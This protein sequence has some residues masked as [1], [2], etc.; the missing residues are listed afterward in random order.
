VAKRIL[1]VALLA[2]T[3]VAC[4]V[5]QTGLPSNV[6]V[7]LLDTLRA[8]ALGIYGH[9]PET[10]PFLRGLAARSAVFERAFSTSSW[11]APSVA[12][13]FTSTYPWEHG[14]TFGFHAHRHHANR[15]WERG[16]AVLPLNQIPPSLETWPE[17]LRVAGYT[18]FAMASNRNL[19]RELG[20][21][22]GFDRFL[23]SYQAP[24][25]EL[26]VELQRWKEDL[27]QAEP[28]FLYLHFNDIHEP[29]EPRLPY[30]EVHRT[31]AGEDES[32]YLSEIG[33]VDW[34]LEEIWHCLD[35]DDSTLFVLL[36]DHGEEFGDHGGTGHGPQLYGELNR[37][38]MMFHGPSLGIVPQ[39]IDANASLIDVLP[40]VIDLVGAPLL[41]TLRGYS[42]A[43]LLRQN[44]DGPRLLEEVESRTLFAHR[45]DQNR[46]E[47][48]LAAAIRGYWKIIRS[49]Q[50]D[51]E[52]YDHRTDLG[53]QSNVFE[54]HPA[55]GHELSSRIDQQIQ[56]TDA[57]DPERVEVPLDRSLLDSL[58]ALGYIE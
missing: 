52:L 5:D 40:T 25:G 26:V 44:S 9:E 27:D 57:A 33:Y 22:R 30:Y 32:R 34:W 14:V 6:V 36:S 48:E 54:E 8:D 1:I 29:Y 35:L 4:G 37:V 46:P 19:S 2:C 7:V 18:T 41:P 12:S 13:L 21:D 24:I 51:L 39:R 11:T 42:L 45:I 38:A 49:S 43:P 47:N 20:F 53:E 56:E 3:V 50:G 31:Y 23:H 15:L 10:A 28:Y 16:E 17:I 55:L 58:E